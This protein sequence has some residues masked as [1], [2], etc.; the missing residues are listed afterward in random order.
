MENNRTRTQRLGG[1]CLGKPLVG[2]ARSSP[3]PRGRTVAP[4]W[5]LMVCARLR[6]TDRSI[7]ANRHR[8]CGSEA[9]AALPGTRGHKMNLEGTR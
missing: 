4:V 2:A 8:V 1:L 3:P 5:P 9:E 7:T 6:V